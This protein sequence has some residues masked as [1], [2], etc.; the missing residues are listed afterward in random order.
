MSS[1]ATSPSENKKVGSQPFSRKIKLQ[2][3]TD[4]FLQPSGWKQVQQEEGKKEEGRVCSFYLFGLKKEPEEK[5]TYYMFWA[6]NKPEWL[7]PQTQWPLKHPLRGQPSSRAESDPTRPGRTLRF[8]QRPTFTCR[9][10]WR[11][12]SVQS[13]WL[14]VGFDSI[15]TTIECL[16]WA[17]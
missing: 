16:L 4:F 6:F 13:I 2:A 10:G 17:T 12:W 11:L 14:S 8:P 3:K 1:W 5:K 9:L 7:H 15:N